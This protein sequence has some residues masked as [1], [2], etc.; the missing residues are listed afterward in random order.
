MQENRERK[1]EEDF[2][3]QLK[4]LDLQIDT[5]NDKL[6]HNNLIREELENINASYNRCL[7][8]LA[9]NAR[10]KDANRKYNELYT[11]NKR[12]H[13]TSIDEIDKQV[14]E[15]RQKIDSYYNNKEMI[16]E[17]YEEIRENRNNE[18]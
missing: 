6:K 9:R 17:E 13:V 5:E 16:E 8:I 10:G 3:Q 12:Q 14:E 18:A 7:Q 15:S 1:K 4:E 2:Q 11:I